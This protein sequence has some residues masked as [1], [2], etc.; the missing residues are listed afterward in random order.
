MKTIRVITILLAVL[1]SA[2]MFSG[3]SSS[4]KADAPL[5]TPTPTPWPDLSTLT[6]FPNA[7][8]NKCGMNGAGQ[9]AE[10]KALNRLKNR[11]RLPSTE[12]ESITFPELLALNQGHA[13]SQHDDIVGFPNSNDP[14]NQRAVTIEGFVVFAFTAGCAQHGATGGESCNCNTTVPALCDTH[15]NV[16]PQQ[17]MSSSGGKNIYVVEV[18]ERIRRLAKLGLLSSNIGKNWSTAKLKAKLEGHRVRFSGFLFFDTDHA[19]QA[20]VSDPQNN[21]GGSHGSNFRQT[22]WEIHPVMAIRVLD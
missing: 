15:I 5:P 13:N 22:A 4:S 1:L 17:G 18:T 20:W 3:S 6:N 21:L 2:L 16:L 7:T 19:N 9:S 14:N 11:F 8:G 12:F 10:K